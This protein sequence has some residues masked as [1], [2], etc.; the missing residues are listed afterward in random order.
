M[1]FLLST[2]CLTYTFKHNYFIY[3]RPTQLTQDRWSGLL[4]LYAAALIPS[5]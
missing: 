5:R 2:S 4:L 1:N 3:N